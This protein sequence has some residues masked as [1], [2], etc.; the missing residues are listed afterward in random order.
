MS[1]PNDFYPGTSE[2]VCLITG[3]PDAIAT[4]VHFLNTKIKVVIMAIATIVHF[5]NTKIK[6]VIMA[7][8]T[9]VRFLNTKIKL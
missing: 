4:I 5:L 6:V 7:I 1:K 3:S 8:A 2:R 9:I